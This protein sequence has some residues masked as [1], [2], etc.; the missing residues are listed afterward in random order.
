MISSI[1]DY[2]PMDEQENM[3][4]RQRILTGQV[5][6]S[7]GSCLSV[8]NPNDEDDHHEIWREGKWDELMPVVDLAINPSLIYSTF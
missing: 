4:F 5:P 6:Y 7:M 1:T 2:D 3:L 8:S